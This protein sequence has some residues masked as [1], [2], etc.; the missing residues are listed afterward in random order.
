MKH[1]SLFFFLLVL[2]SSPTF[3]TNPVHPEVRV[4]S[5]IVGK[6]T[7]TRAEN[8]C[9]EIYEYRE[10]G[11]TFVISGEEK[12][13]GKYAIT[14]T[15]VANGF[16]KIVDTVVKDYGGKDCADSTEDN[17]GESAENFIMFSPKLDQFIVCQKPNLD[18][19]FGPLHRVKD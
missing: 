3:A 16:Y 18:A 4:V 17:T 11:T 15:P 1:T 12:S 7:W 8:N 13:N 10:D 5:P 19:C 2:S 14:L 6:W 9:T